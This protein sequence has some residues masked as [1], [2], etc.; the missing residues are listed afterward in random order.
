MAVSRPAIYGCRMA[1]LI[2]VIDDQEEMRSLARSVLEKAGFAVED[3]E[4]A[5]TALEKVRGAMPP[6]LILLDAV[7][8]DVD[9]FAFL[10]LLALGPRGAKIPVIVCSSLIDLERTKFPEGVNISGTL[11]KPFSAADLL[12]TVKGALTQGLAARF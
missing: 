12:R 5:A 3:F 2:F 4:S 1:A 8:P 10:R 7:M 9:G 11:E 6:A